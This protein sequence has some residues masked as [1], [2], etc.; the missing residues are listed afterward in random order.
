[1]QS[2][3]SR[4]IPISSASVLIQVA[5]A[6]VTTAVAISLAAR[7]ADDEY[8]AIVVAA[9]S[10]GFALG[11]FL[12]PSTILRIGYIR[13]FAAAAALCTSAVILLDMFDGTFSWALLRFAIGA[14]FAFMLAAA[15]GWVNAQADDTTRGRVLALHSFF[16]G[17]GLVGSQLLLL[18]MDSGQSGFFSLMAV[19]ISI[20]LVVVCLMPGD[21]PMAQGE[22]DVTV[23]SPTFGLAF[24]SYIALIGAF[25]SGV[26]STV[27][28][29][30]APFYLSEEG[31]S[32]NIVALAV[33]AVFAGRLLFQI[34][35]GISSDRIGRRWTLIILAAVVFALSSA[36]FFLVPN[37]G[38]NVAGD[39]GFGW[40]VA[41]FG[42]L[43]LIGGTT[44][45]IYSVAATVAFDRAAGHPLVR[46]GSTMLLAWSVGSVAGPMTVAIIGPF[47]E[48][49][50]LAVVMMIASFA[51]LGVVVVREIF[52][53]E[54]AKAAPAMTHVLTTSVAMSETVEEVA[55]SHREQSER[56]KLEAAS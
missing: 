7:A 6:T 26:M 5:G 34:P 37:E 52:T 30:L 54:P 1:M 47:F 20:S 3:L 16:V 35:V 29:S 19:L 46:V 38:S 22:S 39:H 50:L 53:T 15:D 40:Q 36:S 12:A 17:L 23:Q 33:G 10:T 18:T 45:P 32:E 56:R 11:C 13:A 31:V 21:A 44:L 25:L 2:A 51:L 55:R 14:N 27:L 8:A 24:T 4:I 43:I 41:S 48:R 9:Y 49:E 42:L 28:I